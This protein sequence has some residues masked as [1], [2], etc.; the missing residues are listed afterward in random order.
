MDPISHSRCIS[1]T[2]AGVDGSIAMNQLVRF[3]KKAAELPGKG[4][5]A[6]AAMLISLSNRLNRVNHILLI[7]RTLREFGMSR[8]TA[9]RSLVQL[10]SVGLVRVRRHKG[11]GP[12]VSFAHTSA[13]EGVQ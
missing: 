13:G 5:L 4:P 6:T 3:L 7:P 12:L 8:T 11:Q 1:G 9:Y 2:K 10:E